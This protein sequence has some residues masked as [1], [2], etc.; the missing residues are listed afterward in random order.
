M[1]P[2]PSLCTLTLALSGAAI[3]TVF[4]AGTGDIDFN[5]DI[6]PILADNCY[7]CHGPDS[8]ARKAGL[9]LDR[10]EGALGKNEDGLAMITPGNPEKSEVIARIFS[11]D[12]DDVMPSVKSNRTL[13]EAQK[14][15]LKQ[16]VAQGAKWG[17]HWAFVA[18]K[19]ASFAASEPRDWQGA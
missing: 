13:T 9:R 15:L 19:R 8:A 5:R 2:R 1:F 10:K 6:Q 18:P 7:H 12:P 4:A 11:K 3:S 16:W 17:E 14:Q